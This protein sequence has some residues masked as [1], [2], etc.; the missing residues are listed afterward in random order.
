MA[1]HVGGFGFGERGKVI[2]ND[3]E[4]GRDGWCALSIPAKVLQPRHRFS[5]DALKLRNGAT[6]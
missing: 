6:N 4:S 5:N 1:E 3:A 2:E